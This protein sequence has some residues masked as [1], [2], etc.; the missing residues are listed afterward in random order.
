MVGEH[1][2]VPIE[3][4]NVQCPLRM[5]G[6]P[7]GSFTTFSGAA[8]TIGDLCIDKT[9]ATVNDYASCAIDEKCSKTDTSRGCNAGVLNAGNQPINCIDWNQATAY[10]AWAGKRLPTEQEW[11]WVAR[12]GDKGDKFPWGNGAPSSQLCWDGLGNDVGKGLRN[13]TCEVASHPYGVNRWGV[14]DLAGNVA[15]WTSSPFLPGVNQYAV[16]GGS[17][18]DDVADGVA[19][20]AR[21][22]V[23][24]TTRA[25]FIGV[26]CA[27]AP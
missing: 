9:E 26:R 14:H 18:N 16:R 1:L 11:E 23:G 20:S 12:N 5:V 17:W 10:C 2:P 22:I 4:S 15:E 6:I 24:P 8:A 25:A 3:T 19:A 27:K 21:A 13:A 7:G